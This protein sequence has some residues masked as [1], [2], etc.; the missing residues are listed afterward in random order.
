M[1]GSNTHR[2]KSCACCK[3]YLEHLGGKMR[4]FLRRM[5]ADSKHSMIMPDRFVSHFGG[6]IPGT[7]KL[8]SPNG[9]L[10]IVE[11]IECL[12][13]TVLQCG[14]EAFVDAHH[15]KEGESLLFRYIENSRFEVLIL[16]SDDCEKVFSCAGIRNSSCIQDKIVDPVDSSG[17]SSNETTQ[18]SR[19]R[20]TANLTA[21]CSSSEKSGEDSPSGYE[22]HESVDPLTPSWSDYVLS[23]RTYLSEAQKERVVAHIQDIQPEIT[24]FVAVMKK[25]NLQ[26]PAPYLV[27][28]S[29]YAS[30]YFPRESATI[31]LQRPS[32]RKKWYPRFYKRIDKS[33]HMLRGQ[34]KNF[35]HDNCLQEEDICLFV[36]TKGGR[37][38]TFTV[39]LLRAAATHYR[40][41]TDVHKI[42]GSSHDRMNTKMVSQI[43]I[44]QTPGDGDNVSSE[45][46]KHGASHESPENEDSDGPSEPPY[47][48][49]KRR[50]RLSQLQ[51]KKVEEKVRAIQSEFPICVAIISKLSGGGGNRKFCGLELSSRYAA[52]YLP[53]AN[54]QTLVLQCKGMIWQINLV[55]HRYTKG[56]RWFL[57][58][59]WR[60]FAHDNRLRVGD[61]CLFELK[62]KKLTMEVHI[63]SNLQHYP[64]TYLEHLGG[65]MSCFLRRMTADS[66]HS[67]IIPNRFV[68]HF[69]G[70]IPG[71]I[72][73]ESPNGILYVVEVTECM[74]KTVL[75]CGWEAFVDAHHIKVGDS[76]LFR[77]IENFCFEVM[78]L[79]SDGC[80]KVFSC[81]GIK[82][83]FCVQDKTVDPVDTSGSSCD[84]TAQS[85]RSERSAGCQRDTSNDRRNSTASLNAVSSSSEESENVSLK[86]NRNGVSDESQENEDSEGP[87]D[88][89]YI[90][91]CKSKSRLSSLQKKIVEEKVRSIRSEVPI[92]VAIMNRSNVGLT[93]CP[94]QLELGA[95]YAAAVHLPDRRQT[96]VLQRMGQRWD[97]VMQ[98][99]IGRSTRRFLVNGW[100]R[101][102]RDNRLRVGDICLLELKKHER[103]LT[104]TVHTIFSHQ[105]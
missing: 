15:I 104:M 60:K 32:K 24:V 88:L 62:K 10:Y 46:N 101:F 37:S 21:M 6:K 75:Q 85:S 68:S 11:V 65:K 99:K 9:I 34:W 56:K 17:S 30:V 82:N 23:L 90:L 80:E 29:C 42:V 98:T 7:I 100:H 4:C 73:L 20:N 77:H 33:D 67:M 31:T 44:K 86:S 51:K 55:V 54:D 41:G 13:K 48:I 12:N 14:W 79:D 64:E 26:S 43:H 50:C 39:H 66:M 61:F 63:I 93:S 16:D 47:I 58:T 91:P 95:R 27:I 25:C 35:V 69:G 57:T 53:D 102:V 52:S 28:S 105:S 103:K 38:V 22:F 81:A 2:K 72:K 78:I 59:G 96:V 76:L 8:E 19:S 89:P 71:T 83:S 74:N 87:A 94:C 3:E 18:S 84:D 92:Y 97:T 5:A 1:A 36:P 49:S 70:K 45:S 40:N